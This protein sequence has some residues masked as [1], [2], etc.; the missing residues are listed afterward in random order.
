MIPE[1]ILREYVDLS[2]ARLSILQLANCK[3][4]K[5]VNNVARKVMQD[6]IY[7]DLTITPYGKTLLQRVKRL[8][9]G[10]IP[11]PETFCNCD[12]DSMDTVKVARLLR[13]EYTW[14]RSVHLK[15]MR[16]LYKTPEIA[17]KFLCMVFGDQPINMLLD[18]GLILGERKIGS[19]FTISESGK[20]LLIRVAEIM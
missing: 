3:K 11:A 2:V 4:L 5:Q 19:P 9:E 1:N 6:A 20:C 12:I 10:K 7:D 15:V 18:K 16:R 8:E 13:K 14:I 17:Y